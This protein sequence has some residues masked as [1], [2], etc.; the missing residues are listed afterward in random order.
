MQSP[1]PCTDRH[2]TSCDPDDSSV[3]LE[4]ETDSGY[5]LDERTRGREDQ[6]KAPSG[7][8]GPS[9][10]GTLPDSP[11]LGQCIQSTSCSGISGEDGEGKK[12]VYLGCATV[13]GCSACDPETPVK[14]LTCRQGDPGGIQSCGGCSQ[15]PEERPHTR[16]GCHSWHVAHVPEGER[17]SLFHVQPGGIQ[18]CG[19]H[20]R[21]ITLFPPPSSLPP[22]RT[23]VNHPFPQAFQVDALDGGGRTERSTS[24]EIYIQGDAILHE[25]V[26]ETVCHESIPPSTRL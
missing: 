25:P 15:L 6:R 18:S 21:T 14:C 12:C 20:T 9:D 4:C 5:L 11:T 24:R 16:S 19:V 3:C 13:E 23:W 7:L 17:W 22:L 10:S 1:D 26:S 2:C 8:S